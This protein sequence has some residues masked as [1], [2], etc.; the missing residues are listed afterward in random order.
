MKTSNESEVVQLRDQVGRLQVQLNHGHSGFAEFKEKKLAE[1]SALQNEMQKLKDQNVVCSPEKQSEL[2]AQI[3]CLNDELSGL[4]SR[5]AE[6]S[7][8]KDHL[9]IE[10]TSLKSNLEKLMSENEQICQTSNDLN[11]KLDAAIK[12]K[13]FIFDTRVQQNF[14]FDTRVQYFTLFLAVEND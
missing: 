3:I 13:N 7:Q 12:V 1:M 5:F 8:E 11:E 9:L 6:V 10:V 14:I 2:T 4:K